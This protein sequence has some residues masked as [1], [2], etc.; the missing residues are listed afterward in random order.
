MSNHLIFYILP[1]DPKVPSQSGVQ[2]PVDLEDFAQKIRTLFPSMDIQ[3]TKREKYRSVA[4][5]INVEKFGP[6]IVGS[7][8]MNENTTFEISGWPK[9]IATQLIMWYRKY[10]PSDIN[11]YLIVSVNGDTLQLKEN[12]SIEEIESIY[13]F[14]VLNE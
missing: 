4:L 10:I 1:F 8:V 2:L 11:L 3:V 9:N 13:P 12:T 6:W 14:D 7:F 5:Y